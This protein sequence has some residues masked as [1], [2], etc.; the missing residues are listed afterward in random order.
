MT[1]SN[2]AWDIFISYAREDSEW[3]RKNLYDPLLRCHTADGKR[4]RIFFDVGAEGIAIGQNFMTALVNAISKSKK[5]VPVYSSNYFKKEMCQFE[6][7]KAHQLDPWG[8]SAKLNP[9]L[10]DP[11][12][13]E[14]V[15]LTVNHINYWVVTSP[16]W[17]ERLCGALELALADERTV[18][19]FLDQPADTTINYT[20]RPLRVAVIGADGVGPREEQIRI[21]IQDGSLEG[22]LTAKTE[23]GIAT[24]TDLSVSTATA[25]TSLIASAEGHDDIHSE[26][27]AVIKP[28]SRPP[29]VEISSE[30][31]IEERAPRIALKGE[32]V[33][34]QDGKAVVVIMPDGVALY[35][36]AGNS[37]LPPPG[38][39]KLKSRLRLVRRAGPILALADWCGHIYVFSENR[40]HYSCACGDGSQGFVV[41][42]GLAVAGDKVYAGFWNGMVYTVGLG[43]SPVAEFKHDSGV[44]ALAVVGERFYVCGF[45]GNLCVYKNGRMVNSEMLDP[46]VR[47]LQPSEGRLVAAGESKL[48]QIEIDRLKVRSEDLQLSGVAAV[49]GDVALPV[50][51]DARGKGVR[52]NTELVKF[53][54]HVTAGAGPVSADD[55]GRYCVFV[56]PDGSRTLMVD[57]RIVFSHSGG[58]LSMSPA[59]D[60]FAMGDENGIRV[61]EASSFE[62]LIQGGKT[63]G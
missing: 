28:V 3:V 9:I 42:G 19:Q 15:P 14:Q 59:A 56:N 43:Q 26:T 6:L 7:G 62:S 2:A 47:L 18:L 12:A 11:A 23:N 40:Q 10:I 37:L 38:I 31:R 49:L 17:F 50:V 29:A 1:A 61:L 54:F 63:G 51:L 55:G 25:A 5:F 52:F 8:N 34:F 45:D 46:G 39:V 16:D 21:S 44:Q 57:G 32:A 30:D 20:L 33:F 60:L 22:T 53:G 27:F 13:E 58:T 36:V 35:D 48:Y 24:F 41:P 4:P